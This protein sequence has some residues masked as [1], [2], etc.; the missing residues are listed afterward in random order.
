LHSLA[1]ESGQYPYEVIV[2]DNASTDETATELA[3]LGEALFADRFKLLRFDKNRNFGP[4]CNAAARVAKAPLLFFLNNDTLLTKNWAPPLVEALERDANLGAV[5]PLLLYAD[6]TVQHLGI[7]FTVDGF[8][9]LYRSFP[10]DHPV[11]TRKR[12]LQGLT[13]AAMMIRRAVFF[14]AGAFYAGYKNGI[15][16]VELGLRVRSLG[17]KL[18]CIPES[19]IYHL[20][21]KTRGRNPSERQNARLFFSRCGSLFKIDLHIHGINDGFDAFIAE[22]YKI[23]LRL[24]REE[25]EALRLASQDK[26]MEERLDMAMRNPYWVGGRMRLADEFLKLGSGPKALKLYSEVAKTLRSLTLWRQLTTVVATGVTDD[27][28]KDAC[29]SLLRE[30][31]ARRDNLDKTKDAL[32]KACENDSLLRSLFEAKEG[33]KLL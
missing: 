20:E 5:G 30:L 7:F 8:D 16:D 6:N 28:D 33:H 13:G 2:A 25:E 27:K 29:L 17:K 4:A 10:A 24:R 31:S 12:E 26:S 1:A 11:V 9:H 23:G 22:D 21:G 32:L 3:P 18:A 19:V 14:E 15:E